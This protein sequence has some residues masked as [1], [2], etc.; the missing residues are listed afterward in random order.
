MERGYGLRLRGENGGN[1][2][3]AGAAAEGALAGGHLV[4][5]DSESKDVSA[6]VG[7]VTFELLRSHVLKSPQDDAVFGD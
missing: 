5:H 1:E 6:R 2:A 4:K 7:F 3:G